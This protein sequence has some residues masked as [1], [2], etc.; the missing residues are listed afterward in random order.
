[1]GVELKTYSPDLGIVYWDW[2]DFK[3]AAHFLG[4]CTAQCEERFPKLYT[5]GEGYEVEGSDEF[6]EQL[7]SAMQL[8]SN[9]DKWTLAAAYSILKV[10]GDGFP[11]ELIQ[12]GDTC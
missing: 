7:R 4:W 3:G 12:S 1:M 2:T 8:D 5:F 10:L 9:M 6:V 11:D